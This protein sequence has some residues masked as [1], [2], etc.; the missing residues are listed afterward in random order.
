M[1]KVI[2]QDFFERPADIV[3]KDLLGKRIVR[4]NKDGSVLA[5]F[6]ISET[7][8]Y[9][10]KDDKASHAYKGLTERTKVMYG[11]AG[12]FYVYLIYGM[13]YMLNIVTEKEAEPHAVLLRGALEVQ[14]PGRLAKALKID[15]RFNGLLASQ[16]SLLFFA[17]TDFDLSKYRI[18]RDKRVGIDYAEEWKDKKLRFILKD[19]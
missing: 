17:E 12:H 14:G 18:V 1:F 2:K 4:L 9:L 19:V 5:D 15:K 10:G 11:P 13:H 3:A 6:I 7:E 16:E 8:A